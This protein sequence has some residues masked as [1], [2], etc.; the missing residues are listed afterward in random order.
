MIRRF[1]ASLLIASIASLGIALPAQAVLI[2]SELAM[3]SAERNR[4]SSL[5]E[6]AE[7]RSQL[8]AYGVDAAQVKARVAALNDEEVAQLAAQLD[9][10]PAG[11]SLVGAIVLVFLVLL[12]T[13]I[14]GFTKVF[15]FT[16]TVR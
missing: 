2:P 8:Q 1:I 5:L 4:I 10:L 12:V 7:V 14:L 11:G 15:P 3:A 9:R 6:R 13:D 16:R